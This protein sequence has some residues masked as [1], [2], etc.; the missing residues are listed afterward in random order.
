MNC[1]APSREVDDPARHAAPAPEPATGREVLLAAAT[2]AARAD[3]GSG[4][5]GH[6]TIEEPDDTYQYWTGRPCT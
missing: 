6:V 1:S 5:Y 2:G 3:D 4:A